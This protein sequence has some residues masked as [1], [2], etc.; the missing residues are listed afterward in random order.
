MS[1]EVKLR[2]D[3]LRAM[4]EELGD[5]YE[6]CY[7]EELK[8]F[9][10]A[11]MVLKHRASGARI[12]LISNDDNNKVFCV[13]FRTPPFDST[14]VAH[15]IEHTVLCGSE[16]FPAKDPFIELAKG[17]LNTFLNA[18][19]FPDKTIYP[20]ASC[21]DKDFQNLM[22]V[23]M[24]AVFHP[25]IYKKKEIFMQ[26]GWHY[27]IA[28][29][30]D[31]LS[32]NGIVYSEM[33]GAFSS[34]ERVVNLATNRALFPDSPYGVESG[35]DPDCIPDLTYEAYLDFHRRYYH[36]SNSYIYLYGDMDMK[37]KL[38][39]L[40]EAYL[41]AYQDCPVDS[42]VVLQ[43]EFGGIRECTE[44]YSIGENESLE[45][46]TYLSLTMTVGES[47]DTLLSAAMDV[48]VE[49][50]FNV[51]GA[52][53][54]QALIDAGI[55]KDILS[56]YDDSLRQPTFSVMAKN[57]NAEQKEQFLA[58]IMDT[59]KK[60]VKEG[61]RENALKAVINQREFAYRE[62]DYGRF[63]KGLLFGINMFNTWLYDDAAAFDKLKN[64]EVYETLKE[65]IG[66][67]YYEKLVEKWLINT[68]HAVL[69]VLVPEKGLVAKKEAALKEKLAA[70]KESLS[71]E[72]IEA[73]VAQTKSLK[74]FQERPSTKEELNAIPLLAR[75]DLKREVEP[76][77]NEERE[78]A[79]CKAVFHNVYTSGIAYV[80]LLFD[81]RRIPEESV[82]YLGLLSNVLGMM[83]AGEYGY[84][85]LSEEI[86]RNTGGIRTSMFAVSK[87][88]DPEGF[89]EY[90]QIQ[91]KCLYEQLTEAG[92]LTAVVLGETDFTDTKR[93]YELLMEN[94]SRMQ[95]TMMSAG[96]AVAIRR[97]MSYFSEKSAFDEKTSG[98]DQYEF[99]EDLTANFEQK[100]EEAVK[101]LS[102]L[103]RLLFSKDSLLIS[104]TADEE[105]YEAVKAAA[106]S[107]LQNC[108]EKRAE[109]APVSFAAEKKNEGF[110]TPGQVQYVAMCGNYKLAGYEYT[111][112][113]KVVGNLF[114]YDYLW[115]NIRVK[116]GAYGC[117]CSF[118]ASAGDSYLASYRDP[119]L[120]ETIQVY[121]KAAEYLENYEADEREMTK[122]II[123][124]LSG[125]D[126]PL[127]PFTR[128]VRSLNE[129]L[130]GYGY[131]AYQKERN[132]VLDAT[133]E[134]IRKTA[135]LI[136]AIV[137]QGNLCVIGSETRIEKD[138]EV[139]AEVKPL[140][141]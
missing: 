40:D 81:A 121:E 71:R 28:D 86:N 108:A 24:D 98:I 63:P 107:F 77:S 116:G 54:K 99:I 132:E 140:I 31:E 56:G 133:P 135:P 84:Q 22:D 131:E 134:A 111:G 29:A 105:G 141:K 117:M 38:L 26:E 61:L 37:E 139:F 87:N 122:A 57:A 3:K 46:N 2:E 16:K 82:P 5:H 113:L 42:E 110:K 104:V 39:W 18:M 34:A 20:V 67:G 7:E 138:K 78:L 130:C 92:R 53:V 35:G 119:N 10:S 73:L 49:V 112:A 41:A 103:C 44:S 93:L 65:K 50:L 55:G 68:Q 23:Y 48:I 36:P 17:S 76:F 12:A 32:Y 45:D 83:N 137:E 95:M 129:Y 47:S 106:P 89:G 14:G 79:G 102:E 124:T 128:G 30:D 97:A 69:T 27:E 126:V 120:T 21:N 33:K 25:N 64:N 58:V 109:Y 136:R 8:D 9:K 15:I 74:E 13:G 66:T 52:P 90:F 11:G 91:I 94:R 1:E 75:E 6:L 125:M 123:G 100:K 62:S 127:T 70:Y 88:G 114:D 101:K 51:P 118:G 60:T 19:T 80:T 43:K 115:N 4:A 59:L 85:E 96:H 72:K